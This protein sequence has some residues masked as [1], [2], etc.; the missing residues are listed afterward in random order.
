LIGSSLGY[1]QTARTRTL[2][3]VLF[4][5]HIAGLLGWWPLTV[6]LIASACWWLAMLPLGRAYRW[7]MGG[8]MLA[9]VVGTALTV[10]AASDSDRETTL[11]MDFATVTGFL[12]GP[13]IL[14][15]AMLLL[16]QGTGLSASEASW[17][18]ARMSTFV[19][20]VVLLVAT[21]LARFFDLLEASTE[22][23]GPDPGAPMMLVV[24]A[25][26]AIAALLFMIALFDTQREIHRAIFRPAWRRDAK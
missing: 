6:V 13:L 22:G 12:A 23:V 18:R 10:L 11:G 17:R 3:L 1:Q 16:S 24:F 19:A 2:V 14:S 21:L 25:S 7:C 4:F 26:A 9:Y 8:A 20:A 15:Q 5:S